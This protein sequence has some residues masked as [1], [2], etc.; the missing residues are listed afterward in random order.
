MCDSLAVFLFFGSTVFSFPTE[1]TK[2]HMEM[3]QATSLSKTREV[4]TWYQLG[5]SHFPKTNQI[6]GV[7]ILGFNS[8][9]PNKACVNVPLDLL[10]L[11][12]GC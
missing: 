1:R 7:N 6:K 10:C 8:T 12:F 3:A 9:V 11:L 5:C 2:D 4:G